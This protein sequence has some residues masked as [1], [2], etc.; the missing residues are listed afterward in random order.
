MYGKQVEADLHLSLHSTNG[1]LML[2]AACCAVAT[3][4]GTWHAYEL[5]G[6]L[7]VPG[8][9]LASPVLAWCGKGVGVVWGRVIKWLVAAGGLLVLLLRCA[10]GYRL[11]KDCQTQH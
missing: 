9:R 7:W 6:E 1:I 3:S 4:A 11:W 8:S 2:P 10:V 5:A